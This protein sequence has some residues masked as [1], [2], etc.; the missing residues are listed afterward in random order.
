MKIALTSAVEKDQSR[1]RWARGQLS[2]RARRGM[3]CVMTSLGKIFVVLAAAM[4]TSAAAA[5]TVIDGDTIDYKGVVLHLWGVDAPEKG[6]VC[7]DNWPAGQAAIDY[8]TGLMKGREVSCELKTS[9]GASR[10]AALCTAGGKDLS[11]EMARAGLAWALPR[12]TGEYTV[13]ETDAMAQIRGV[14]AH[15][16]LKAWEWRERQLRK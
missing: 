16:C 6:Q 4:G 5:Q 2:T 8:L 1:A 13:P 10:V 3:T 12:E 15:S 14:H 11:A 9:D 7:A